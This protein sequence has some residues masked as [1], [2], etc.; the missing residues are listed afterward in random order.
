MNKGT[1]ILVVL[2]A[3]ILAGCS[4]EP[5]ARP[6]AAPRE[7]TAVDPTSLVKNGKMPMD[8]VLTG[9]QPTDDQLAALR[10]AGFQTVINL[11]Q[12]DEPGTQGEAEMMAGLGM[13]YVAI[14]VAGAAGL[15]EENAAALA[16]ALD[17]AAGPVLLHC[18]SGNRVGAL[19]A[20]KAFWLDG[21]SAEEALATGI[22]GGVTSLEPTVRDML[23]LTD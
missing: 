4:A 9:G 10:D 21:A 8:G 19:L 16:A 17:E 1:V 7:A 12:P 23:G 11:R 3:A 18:G 2:T 5:A 15:T 6:G 14:P 20:L 13:T 22:A